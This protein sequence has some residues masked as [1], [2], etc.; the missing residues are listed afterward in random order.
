MRY[1]LL[2]NSGLRVSELALG[3][4]TFGTETG[5]GVDKAESRQVYDAFREAGGNFIDTANV[6]AAGT[7][8][9]FLGEFLAGDR[10]RMV[11]ATKYTGGMRGR[12]INATGNA[13][14]N[15][16]DSVHASLKRLNTDYIDLYWVHARDYLTPIE[17]VMRGLDD[18][19]S[20]GKVHYVGVSDTPAWVVS[21]ANTIA[22][23]RGWSPFVGLQIRY[24]LVDRTVERE[25]LPMARAL[26]LAVTPWGIVGSGVLTGKYNRNPEAE[27]RARMRGQINDRQ[28]AIAAET[29]AVA[30]EL[31]VSPSQVAIAW[32]RGGEGNIIPL[33]GARTRAQLTENLGALDVH[34][35]ASQRERLNTASAISVG[36]P[37]D[38]LRPQSQA[39]A[40]RVDNHRAAATP[41]W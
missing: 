6:Y 3:A 10:E 2:G 1:R 5:F 12:D 11:I 26:D 9:T 15:M 36:F 41:E 4:M 37:H 27:G 29:M 40:K 18:L 13:R 20:Q 38:M 39:V 28:L 25:L 34:L 30:E 16:M 17:E 24:S 32:V 7:S 31:D 33:V 8:E 35:S 21:Q 19:V 14:K 22:A 23:F